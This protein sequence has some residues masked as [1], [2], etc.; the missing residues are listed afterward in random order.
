M[1]KKQGTQMKE[2]QPLYKIISKINLSIK[3]NTEILIEP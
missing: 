2:I 1:K 3:Q